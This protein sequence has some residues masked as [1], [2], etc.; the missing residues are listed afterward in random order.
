MMIERGGG[1][2]ARADAPAVA[3][4]RRSGPLAHL[5]SDRWAM[6]GAAVALG[7]VLLAVFAPLLSG[8]TGNDPYAYHLGEL[9]GS[10]V[11]RGPFGGV[12]SSHWLGV[13]PQTG[14]DLFAIVAYGARVSLGVGVGAT[15]LATLIGTALGVLAGYSGGLVDTLLSRFTD[16]TIAFPQL[17]FM[18]A[19][20]AVVPASFPRQFFMIFVIGVFG[21][22][23]VARVVR[24]QTLALRNRS[25]VVAARAVGAGPLHILR[26]EILPN[27]ASTITV[28]ATIFIP[29]AIGTEAALS[30]LGIGVPPPTPSW[31]REISSAI[32]WVVVDPW[33][34]AGPGLALFSVT[35]ALNAFG[36]GLRD[37]L[38]P[39]MPG[40]LR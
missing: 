15:L 34:L 21:W 33:Y 30:F 3:A 17:I 2:P 5:L 10:G 12:G 29:D 23:K 28:I 24:G 40:R 25:F 39:R 27:L 4:A 7:F 38:D 19:L 32:A 18:I 11:P 26:T 22:P 9:A 8:I 6:T 31:G 13:E 36:D 14:R 37:A 35:L 1:S 16:L 20:G